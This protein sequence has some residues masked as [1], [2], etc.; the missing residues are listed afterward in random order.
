V[1]DYLVNPKTGKFQPW[2]ELVMDVHYDSAKPM[3]SVFV[4]TA[5][6]SSLRFFLDMMV[7]LHK[8][9]M[10]VGGKCSRQCT[11]YPSVTFHQRSSV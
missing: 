4:P 6:T 7:D 8:P 3:S 2:A 5:E 1:Y 9:I 10:F 11:I